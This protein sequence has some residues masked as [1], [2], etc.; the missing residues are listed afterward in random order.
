[1]S[2]LYPLMTATNYD[3]AAGQLT[4]PMDAFRELSVYFGTMPLSILTLLQTATL[5]KWSTNIV[6]PTL[7][8]QQYFS[9]LILIAF[10]VVTSYGLLKVLVALVVERMVAVN[11][12]HEAKVYD[13]QLIND[14][15]TYRFRQAP[16]PVG[17][18][19]FL[20]APVGDYRFLRA[21]VGDYRFLRAPVAGFFINHDEDVLKTLGDE[22]NGAERNY[23]G[24]VDWEAFMDSCGSSE[25]FTRKIS[26]ID[27]QAHDV[28]ELFS[29]M[30][31]T[32]EDGLTEEEFKQGVVR[33]KRHASGRDVVH[34]LGVVDTAYAKVGRVMRSIEKRDEQVK[35][36]Q[37]T[38]GELQVV[39]A[40]MAERKT[41]VRQW[42]AQDA[43]TKQQR[44]VLL[45]MLHSLEGEHH[46]TTES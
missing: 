37:W 1:M 26:A 2:D 42:R 24:R 3:A 44:K 41:K 10:V 9:A 33:L 12:E 23:T 11:A 16:V 46:H 13:L 36:I 45:T 4:Y 35:K 7:A 40:D 6:R 22:F 31:V 5:D 43:D 39:I 30:N 21:P 38:L 17:D 18:Y 34:L 32:A 14:L 19:R 15:S 27:F 25:Q 28:K 29:L 8:S 20:R